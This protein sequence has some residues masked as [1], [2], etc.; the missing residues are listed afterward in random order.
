M[1]TNL[2]ILG[3]PHCRDDTIQYVGDY[4]IFIMGTW[5]LIPRIVVVAY[6]PSDLHGIRSGLIHINHWGYK[7]LTIRGMSHQVPLILD[8]SFSKNYSNWWLN[9]W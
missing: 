1:F 6:N 2:A 3:A 4:H 8:A 9:L 7:P 5:W